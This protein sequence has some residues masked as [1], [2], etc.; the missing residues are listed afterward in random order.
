MTRLSAPQSFLSRLKTIVEPCQLLPLLLSRRCILPPL[1][2]DDGHLGRWSWGAWILDTSDQYPR[3]VHR[4]APYTSD[5]ERTNRRNW[6]P[7]RIQFQNQVQV[8][9]L[10]YISI[11][12]HKMNL[13]PSFL[14]PPTQQR[15][16]APQ[17]LEPT[18]ESTLILSSGTQCSVFTIHFSLQNGFDAYDSLS[19]PRIGSCLI[20]WHCPHQSYHHCH[21]HCRLVY[22]PLQP[23]HRRH[24]LTS[25]DQLKSLRL[26]RIACPLKRRLLLWSWR[27]N[28]SKL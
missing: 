14:Q 17:I 8:R 2:E 6:S 4:A 10:R 15:P 27:V 9:D 25:I 19:H 18:E 28:E 26:K 23:H 24:C 1:L 7:M 22:H 13:T 21:H 3:S 20:H 12:Y 11:S 16:S 5:T